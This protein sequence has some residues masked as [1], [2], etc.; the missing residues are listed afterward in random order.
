MNAQAQSQPRQREVLYCPGCETTPVP[1]LHDGRIACGRCHGPIR[2][3][4]A[5]L[6]LPTEANVRA[7]HTMLQARVKVA[8]IKVERQVP[9]TNPGGRWN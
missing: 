8:V 6:P 1:V 7:M 4:P 5:D 3:W 9:E 2:R